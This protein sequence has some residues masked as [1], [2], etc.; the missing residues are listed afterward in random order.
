MISMNPL[1][2]AYLQ[3]GCGRCKFGGSPRCKVHNWPKELEQ[4]RRI[5]H[6]CGLVEELKW[7]VPCYTH[8][9]K[10]IAIVAAFKEYCALSFFKGTLL[11]DEHQLFEKPGESTQSV[12]IMKFTDVNKVLE[13]EPLIKTY[14]FE[15]IEVENAG[16]KVETKKNI[17]PIPEELE[18]KMNAFPDFKN[19][20]ESLTPGRK[21]GYI[22]HF[23]QPKQSSTRISRIE[24]NMEKIMKGKGI[25]E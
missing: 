9:N 3:N 19:A 22:L 15:A 20:F 23:S 16:L 25:N 12:R 5:V 21:R 7:S 14:V 1:I 2:D 6:E 17:E 10:N 4:L 8:Q 11:Q 13:L 24:R 18:L